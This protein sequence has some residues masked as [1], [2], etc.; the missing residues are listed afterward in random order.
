MNKQDLAL[1]NLLGLIC[2]KTQPTILISLA[3]LNFIHSMKLSQENIPQLTDSG[4]KAFFFVGKTHN[5]FVELD[6]TIKK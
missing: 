4:G 2:H 6:W 1:N 5:T 3:K